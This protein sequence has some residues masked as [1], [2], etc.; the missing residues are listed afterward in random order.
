MSV[1][2]AATGSRSAGTPAPGLYV[3]G[4]SRAPEPEA[5]PASGVNGRFYA[6]VRAELKARGWSARELA[7]RAGMTPNF[8][9]RTGQG[10]WIALESAATVADVL[11]VPL[12]DLIAGDD[13]ERRQPGGAA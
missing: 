7:R 10:H 4:A 6:S 13:A 2:N 12:C 3:Y 9:T 1:R 8:L 5:P 11:G